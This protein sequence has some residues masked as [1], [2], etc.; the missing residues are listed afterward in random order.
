MA[1]IAPSMV[2]TC[3]SHG[4][5]CHC[6]AHMATV[7]VAAPAAA[8]DVPAPAAAANIKGAEEPTFDKMAAWL[9]ERWLLRPEESL[10][11]EQVVR[12][13]NTLSEYAFGK[14]VG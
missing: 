10:S 2:R 11:E 13:Y 3:C 4:Q 9:T 12:L 7:A 14:A 6:S 8:E 1:A 5:G